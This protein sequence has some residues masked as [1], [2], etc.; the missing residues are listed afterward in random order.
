MRYTR[1]QLKSWGDS[2]MRV[3]NSMLCQN[4]MW[5]LN[6]NLENMNKLSNQLASGK[7]IEKPS[8]DPVCAS[9]SLKYRTY[10]SQI[11][12][13]Q[14]NADDAFA[15]MNIT[16]QSLEQT[17]KVINRSIELVVQASNDT[18]T[19]EEYEMIAAEI[20][21]LEKELIEIGNCSYTG[22]Y[23]F[24][25]YNTDDP[26]FEVVDT[27]VGEKIMYNGN[28]LS[29]GGSVSASVSDDDYL[30]F[31]EDNK[32]QILTD[33]DKN[34]DMMYNI[35]QISQVDVNV[36]GY[37]LF[38]EGLDG[39][40]E[41]FQKIEMAL[42]G[43][44]EYKIINDTVDPPVVETYPL[45]MTQLLEDLDNNLNQ[46]LTVR[47]GLGAKMNYVE[48]SQNRLSD[49]YQTYTELMSKN[50]DVDIAEV[51]MELA[52]AQYVYEASLSASSKIILP[53][54]ADFI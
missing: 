18:L 2:I 15:Y 32:N 43:E 4:V 6:K 33:A 28:Y 37:E 47:A 52:N 46:N 45:E 30:Q 16:E 1:L 20:E 9:K 3:T 7:K 21:Q 29:L 50:E 12:Q 31:Y 10:V 35:G 22:K 11:E 42:S 23:I 25:G 26:P 24:G 40:F 54:L 48:L 17:K 13:Y 39:L 53:S 36:E 27:S 5:N 49:E 51:S 41:T 34:Q 14:K 38:G 19:G 8:D 44:T